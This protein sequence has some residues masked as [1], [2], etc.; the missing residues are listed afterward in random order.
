[1]GDLCNSKH[2]G[3]QQRCH[4]Y[5]ALKELHQQ[6]GGVNDIY[7]NTP[8]SEDAAVMDGFDFELSFLDNFV[9]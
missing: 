2:I 9:Q 6:V 1:M 7:K 8:Q 5:Q 4:E 3:V